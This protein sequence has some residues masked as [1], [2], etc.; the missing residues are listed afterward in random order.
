MDNEFEPLQNLIPIIMVNTTAT[1]E[2]VPEI[3]QRIRLIKECRRGI[4]NTLP[5]KKIPQLMLIELIY[6]V[7]LWLNAFPTKS[8]ISAMLLPREIVLH[9]KLDFAKHCKAPFGSYCESHD[10]PVPSNTMA[11]RTSP[12]IVLG[13]TGNI[14]ST[15]KL[16][17]LES[18]KKMKRRS[19][20][21]SPM[22]NFVIK[23]VEAMGQKQWIHL[24]SLTET[25]SYLNGMKM[26]MT[27][28]N[29]L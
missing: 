1:K 27:K 7:V 17:S 13:P 4:L 24:I 28:L 26:L 16:L 22:P 6:H 20:T 8:G 14:Q 29:T 9:H 3:E 25:E 21:S 2:H 5:Y 18:G 23:Q 11:S 15:Y 12:A 10:K 19:F